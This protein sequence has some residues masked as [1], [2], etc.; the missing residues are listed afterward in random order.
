MPQPVKDES[1]SPKD[2]TPITVTEKSEMSESFSATEAPKIETKE[3]ETIAAPLEDSQVSA[4]EKVSWF[5]SK[6]RIGF[7]MILIFIYFFFSDNK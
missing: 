1:E 2:E 3:D 4:T 7:E 6:I 5:H